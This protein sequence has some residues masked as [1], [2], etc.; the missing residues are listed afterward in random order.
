[1]SCATQGRGVG[2]GSKDPEHGQLLLSGEEMQTMHS[3]GLILG[4]N[5]GS[6]VG[7]GVKERHS[8][9]VGTV[10]LLATSL[11][12]KIIEKETAKYLPEKIVVERPE[13]AQIAEVSE[14]VVPSPAAVEHVTV[15]EEM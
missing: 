8:N 3:S 7:A 13:D 6:L 10:R 12:R 4:G 1:M 15:P 2:M 9:N 5:C 14:E 11:H